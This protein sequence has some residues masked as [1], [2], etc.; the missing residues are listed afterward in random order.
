MFDY[1]GT[2]KLV[3]RY[4]FGLPLV[5]WFGLLVGIAHHDDAKRDDVFGKAQNLA[6]IGDTLFDGIATCPNGAEAEGMGGQK[7]VLGGSRAVLDPEVAAGTFQGLGHVAAN[8][9]G[10]GG[11]MPHLGLTA[12]AA[13]LVQLGAVVDH[14]EMPRLQVDGSRSS[15]AGT[16]KHL[17]GVGCDGLVGERTDAGARHD[18][19]DSVVHVVGSVSGLT[20]V[21]AV[22]ARHDG[23]KQSQSYNAEAFWIVFHSD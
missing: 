6:D 10:Q 23:G 3:I 14:H 2:S 1:K 13:Q 8:D 15:H 16:E 20:I 17:Y 5:L 19:F 7:D 18:S 21:V 12:I 4:V 9:D 11:F 22:A